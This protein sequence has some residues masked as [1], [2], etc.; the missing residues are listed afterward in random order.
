MK[1]FIKGG[2]S[3][4]VN[5]TTGEAYYESVKKRPVLS[6]LN[7]LHYNPSRN[8]TIFSDIFAFSLIIITLTG[9]FMVKGKKGLRGRGGIEL[10]LGIFIPLAFILWG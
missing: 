3:L 9:I 5:T 10:L 7:R 1:V 4:L 2:S 8:W 6:S